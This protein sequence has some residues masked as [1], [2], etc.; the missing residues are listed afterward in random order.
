MDGSELRPPTKPTTCRADDESATTS[1]I[2]G[3]RTPPRGAGRRARGLSILNVR[4]VLPTAVVV[5]S[6]SAPHAP[7]AQPDLAS[8]L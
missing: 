2:P 7:Q 6:R 5:D 3:P 8:H 4:R 1:T